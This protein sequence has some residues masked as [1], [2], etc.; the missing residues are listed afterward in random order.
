[1]RARCD[2]R[3]SG[4]G[5]FYVVTPN[6]IGPVCRFNVYYLMEVDSSEELLPLRLLEVC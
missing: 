1:M 5:P 3:L 2:I 4:I 6:P